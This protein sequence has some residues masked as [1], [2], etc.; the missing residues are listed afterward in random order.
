[1]SSGP[2]TIGRE[3]IVTTIF[4]EKAGRTTVAMTMLFASR[5]ARD[6]ALATGMVRGVAQS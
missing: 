2:T 6:G 3:A 4:T 5:E 1:M